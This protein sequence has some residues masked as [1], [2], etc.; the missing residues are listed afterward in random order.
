[1]ASKSTWVFAGIILAARTGLDYRRLRA[2]EITTAEFN[3]NLRSNTAG[4]I[5]S[6]IGGT[7]GMF[8]GLPLGAYIYNEIGAIV[9]ATL[10]G[11]TGGLIGENVMVSA[12]ERLEEA[13]I[14]NQSN[15]ISTRVSL[16]DEESVLNMQRRTS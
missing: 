7:A 14:Q 13:L 2:D 5:G 12:E 10:L 9:V 15:Q 1:M 11:V 4:T 16:V 6:V 3:H 8:I